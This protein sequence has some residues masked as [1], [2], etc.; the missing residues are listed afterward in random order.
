M[1]PRTNNL[2]VL[3]STSR[4]VHLKVLITDSSLLSRHGDLT[5][6]NQQDF[7]FQGQECKLACRTNSWCNYSCRLPCS[8]D[9]LEGGTQRQKGSSSEEQECGQYIHGYSTLKCPSSLCFPV[10]LS[11]QKTQVGPW[12]LLQDEALA[13]KCTTRL[14]M[15][16]LASSQKRR[17]ELL[18]LLN[19]WISSEYFLNHPGPSTEWQTAFRKHFLSGCSVTLCVFYESKGFLDAVKKA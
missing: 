12:F 6:L 11:K 17:E 7:F 14:F 2:H 5:T 10:S 18:W 1:S 16:T 3:F 4:H 9:F 15:Q 8:A 19:W 13:V